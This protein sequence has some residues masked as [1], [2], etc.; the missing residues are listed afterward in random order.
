MTVLLP[1]SIWEVQKMPLSLNNGVSNSCPLNSGWANQGDHD[2][3]Q[4]SIPPRCVPLACP[5]YK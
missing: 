4:E 1:G 3:R 5:I 2:K